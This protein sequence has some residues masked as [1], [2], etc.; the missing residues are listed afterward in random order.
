[1]RTFAASL[2]AL[3]AFGSL[4]SA[5]RAA[6][7]PSPLQQHRA[8]VGWKAGDAAV[9][10]FVARGTRTGGPADPIAFAARG[11]AFRE[12]TTAAGTSLSI[13]RGFTGSLAWS[14]D[15]NGNV[16]KLHNASAEVLDDAGLVLTEAF[17][18]VPDAVDAGTVTVAGKPARAV[19]VTPRGGAPMTIAFG[20]DGAVLQA[21]IQAQDGAHV[22]RVNGYRTVRDGIRV[23]SGY[24]LDATRVRFN[25]ASIQVVGDAQLKPPAN[26]WTYAPDSFAFVPY[27]TGKGQLQ[28]R[29]PASVNGVEGLFVF[30]TTAP[31]SIVYDEFAR[32]AGL[33]S[34]GTADFAPYNGNPT[35]AGISRAATF[36]VGGNKRHDVFFHRFGPKASTRIAGVIG[37]DILANSAL[38]VDLSA[39][40][41]QMVDAAQMRPSVPP[42]GAALPVDFSDGTPRVGVLLEGGA[43]AHP[44]FDSDLNGLTIFSQALYDAGKL[45]GSQATNSGMRDA[46]AM[47]GGGIGTMSYDDAQRVSYVTYNGTQTSGECLKAHD[48]F[49][50]PFRYAAPFV[51]LAQ[52]AAVGS[53]GGNLGLDFLSH[54]NWTFDL[55]DDQIVLVP[56][57]K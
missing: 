16:R 12:T 36:D 9:P 47:Q 17:T 48:I 10:G 19:R 22:L 37:A 46:G 35:Y 38:A 49:V 34:A 8:F 55:Q 24:D 56:N 31:E 45:R 52:P 14:S 20:D 11:A 51:C 41:M 44:V 33:A 26:A 5:V 27:S 18:L 40:T 3:L 30:D 39:S 29:I 21:T 32:R 57:G 54:F 7:I 4:S 13:D 23:I 25:D 42:G 6:D 28:I 43:V 50:G 53:A 1:M 15:I 2:S